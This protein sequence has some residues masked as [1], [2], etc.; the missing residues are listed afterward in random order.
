MEQ[1]ILDWMSAPGTPW[2]S[3]LSRQMDQAAA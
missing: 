2:R 3:M 1:G